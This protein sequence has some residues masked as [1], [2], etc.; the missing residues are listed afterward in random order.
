MMVFDGEIIVRKALIDGFKG[1]SQA[2]FD[3]YT[4]PI[5]RNAPNL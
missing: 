2:C 1:T 3:T 4:N 5:L